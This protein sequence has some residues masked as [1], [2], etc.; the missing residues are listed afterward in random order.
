ME[1]RKI[2]LSRERD[3]GEIISDSIHFVK[4]NFKPLFKAMLSI[5]FAFIVLS[6]ASGI[7]YQIQV[8]N[9]YGL[10]RGAGMGGFDPD[11]FLSPG[12][13]LLSVAAYLFFYMLAYTSITLAALCYIKLYYE[14]GHQPP[15]QAAVWE[16]FKKRFLM[17]L[18]IS[19]V[20]TVIQIIAF[21]LCLLPGFYLLPIISLA[22]VAVVLDDMGLNDALSRGSA[23]VKD[24]WWMTFGAL[25]VVL[26]IVSVGGYLFAL[27]AQILMLSGMFFGESSGLVMAG[28]IINVI[29][30]SLAIFLHVLFVAATAICYFS[31]REEKEGVGLIG[32]IDAFDET[33]SPNAPHPDEEY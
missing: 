1:P 8:I 17:F 29:I 19:I 6:I 3:F 15:S 11:M 33:R 26:I 32:R 28:S 21:M 13:T 23:L 4:N 18:L 10:D 22:I 9:L 7:A 20:L 25:V 31:L 24:R 14:G 2:E 27:P 5:G 16:A 12:N 30:Q